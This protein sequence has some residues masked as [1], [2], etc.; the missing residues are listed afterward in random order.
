MKRSSLMVISLLLFSFVSVADC[1][2]NLFDANKKYEAGLLQDVI[3]LIKPC[4]DD[5]SFTR[6]EMVMASR[7]LALTYLSLEDE[8]NTNKYIQLLLKTDPQYYFQSHADPKRLKDH[9]GRFTVREQWSVGLSVSSNVS[10]VEVIEPIGVENASSILESGAGIGAGIDIEYKHTPVL[11]FLISPSLLSLNYH[12]TINSVASRK[13][14]YDEN[15]NAVTVDLGVRR[16]LAIGNS[17][18]SAGIGVQSLNLM[19]S[20]GYA[21]TI[22]LESGEKTLYSTEKTALRKSFQLG[23][24]GSLGFFRALGDGRF[25]AELQYTIYPGNFVDPTARYVDAEFITRSNYIDPDLSL[26]YVQLNLGYSY[27]LKYLVSRER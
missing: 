4:V 19:H 26:R 18:L 5:G 3:A 23:F 17:T 2:S 13:L 9:I 14:E 25:K 24:S 11:S 20:Y 7:L 22:N 6:E 8:T 10:N 1:G 12:H 16:Y 27:P 15:I 21:N